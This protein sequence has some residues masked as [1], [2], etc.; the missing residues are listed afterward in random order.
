MSREVPKN[1]E[2]LD[3]ITTIVG[4]GGRRDDLLKG[5][6][7]AKLNEHD[8][9]KLEDKT[10]EISTPQTCV[11]MGYVASENDDRV[12]IDIYNPAEHPTKTNTITFAR[13]LGHLLTTMLQTG[14]NVRAIKSEMPPKA[15]DRKGGF[16]DF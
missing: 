3:Y 5:I 7:S 12:E 4:E 13:T 10:L 1:Y 15:G 14:Y 2:E 8:G 16:R 11:L 6:E 9:K